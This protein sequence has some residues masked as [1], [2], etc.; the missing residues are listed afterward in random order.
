ML[1]CCPRNLHCS[2]PSAGCIESASSDHTDRRNTKREERH[3][4]V[5]AVFGDGVGRANSK[6]STTLFSLITQYIIHIFYLIVLVK[7]GPKM[8]TCR[9]GTEI[10]ELK[11]IKKFSPH[12]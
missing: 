11:G 2:H 9:N 6:Y 3:V 5:M 12:F 8:H 1:F 10:A 7:R 4:V